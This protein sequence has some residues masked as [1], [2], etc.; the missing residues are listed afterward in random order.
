MA[1]ESPAA[2]PT[3]ATLS[4][5]NDADEKLNP[6]HLVDSTTVSEFDLSAEFDITGLSKM[7]AEEREHEET[8]SPDSTDKALVSVRCVRFVHSSGFSLA[9][10]KIS[11]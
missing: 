2:S 6:S 11:R 5:A 4:G 10:G 7:L 8:A 1:F 9:L 3:K